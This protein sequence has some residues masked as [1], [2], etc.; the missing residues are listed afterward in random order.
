MCA[1]S[2][3]ERVSRSSTSLPRWY[4]GHAAL[5]DRCGGS[6]PAAAD[7]WTVAERNLVQAAD[8]QA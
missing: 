7:F 5:D 1:S 4:A 2:D 6:P 8:A 3:N